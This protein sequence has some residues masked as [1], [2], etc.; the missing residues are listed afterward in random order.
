MCITD[1][2]IV[3]QELNNTVKHLYSNKNNKK[4]H[5]PV[6]WLLT[7]SFLLPGF[8]DLQVLLKQ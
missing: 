5:S 2:V 4:E 6:P 8:K 1:L 7:L 3:Q